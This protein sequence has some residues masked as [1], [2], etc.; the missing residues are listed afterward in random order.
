VGGLEN[1]WLTYVSG[2]DLVDAPVSTQFMASIYFTIT[3]ITTTGDAACHAAL[4]MPCTCIP[5]HHRHHCH[6]GGKVTPRPAGYMVLRGLA[7]MCC[8]EHA[9]SHAA[10]ERQE[11]AASHQPASCCVSA[12]YGDVTA[13]NPGEEVVACFIMLCGATFLSFM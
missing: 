2:S 11:H 8:Q 7:S 12:G 9:A 1:S 6:P 10:G 5:L 4:C 13:R 3:T